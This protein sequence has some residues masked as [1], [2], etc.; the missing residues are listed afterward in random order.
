MVANHKCE[1][2]KSEKVR[3][4]STQSQKDLELNQRLNWFSKLN[5]HEFS[6]HILLES[7]FYGYCRPNGL[8]LI[9]KFLKSSAA[10][11]K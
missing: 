11:D 5:D 9:N 10:W 7:T 2:K 4:I 8:A 3:E 6:M 1:N